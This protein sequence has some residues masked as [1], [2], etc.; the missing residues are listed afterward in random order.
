MF[1]DIDCNMC[2]KLSCTVVSRDAVAFWG[3]SPMKPSLQLSFVNLA[4]HIDIAANRQTGRLSIAYACISGRHG[5]QAFIENRE[6]NIMPW[7][8]D[9]RDIGRAH[10]LAAE[11]TLVGRVR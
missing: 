11:V 10:V 4:T 7:I 2:H 8:V 9:V 1:V 5:M 3:V 6:D